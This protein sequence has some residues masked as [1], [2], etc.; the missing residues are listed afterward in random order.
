MT[1]THTQP[2][3]PALPTKSKTLATWIALAGGSFGLH[4]FYLY[5]ARDWPAWLHPW[6]TLVGLAGAVR[7]NNLGQD[8]TLAWVLVPLLGMMISVGMVSAIAIG[9]TPDE[10]WAQRFGGDR[11]GAETVRRTAWGPIFGV[12]LALFIG[13]AVLMGTIAFSG[14]KYF[15]WQALSANPAA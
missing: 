15:E 14:Q 7:M 6:P 1:V 10:R 5:G 9:L 4:R 11:E 2:T 13:G 8:D 12:I 3:P